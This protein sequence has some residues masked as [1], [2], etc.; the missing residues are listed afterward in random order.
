LQSQLKNAGR[1]DTA[2]VR[3]LEAEKSNFEGEIERLTRELDARKSSTASPAA[4]NQ[5]LE[6]LVQRLQQELRYSKD[7]FRNMANDEIKRRSD[8]TEGPVLDEVLRTNYS[9]IVG[10]IQAIAR[11][12][13]TANSKA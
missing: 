5:K 6:E 12:Y 7:Q 2:R 13:Y 1:A 8:E 11:T 4:E 10:L 9:D 3:Q